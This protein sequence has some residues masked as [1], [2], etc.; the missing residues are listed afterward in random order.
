MRPSREAPDERL[1]RSALSPAHGAG[2]VDP[3][4][5]ASGTSPSQAIWG[6]QA[7]N[8]FESTVRVRA[9][10]E[11]RRRVMIFTS[12]D[13]KDTPT[14]EAKRSAGGEDFRGVSPQ[15]GPPPP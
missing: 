8:Y 15:R 14:L 2:R 5:P 6:D 4:R 13:E 12:P 11:A 1:C 3:R 10:R 7:Q 9:A